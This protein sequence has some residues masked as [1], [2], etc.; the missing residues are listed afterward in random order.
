[1]EEDKLPKG[2]LPK[3]ERAWM[4]DVELAPWHAVPSRFI[5]RKNISLNLLI[6]DD[7]WP[8]IHDYIYNILWILCSFHNKP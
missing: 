6:T 2:V 3:G 4:A 1:M 7:L 5:I 8:K